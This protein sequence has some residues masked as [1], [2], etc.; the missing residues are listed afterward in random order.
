MKTENKDVINICNLVVV[1]LF[2]VQIFLFAPFEYFLSNRENIWFNFRDLIPFAMVGFISSSVLLSLVLFLIS[3]KSKKLF[4]V[5]IVGIFA[6]CLSLYIQGT[7]LITNMGALD[8]KEPDWSQYMGAKWISICVW[9]FIFGILYFAL[10]K[11]NYEKLARM[12]KIVSICLILVQVVTILTVGIA[13]NGFVSKQEMLACKNDQFSLSKGENFIILVLDS[14]DAR[15]FERIRNE[16]N[17]NEILRDFTYYNNTTPSFVLTDL[18][19]PQIITGENYAEGEIYEEY[20]NQAFDA[21]PLLNYLQDNDWNYGIYTST[22]LGSVGA[23]NNSINCRMGSFTV[24]S[25]RRLAKYMYKLLGMRYLP[26]P[27]QKYCW[28]YPDEMDNL[29]C[30]QNSK[31]ELYYEFNMPFYEEMNQIEAINDKN[32]F[33]FYHIDGTHIPYTM[34]RDV[35]STDTTFNTIDEEARG[36]MVIISKFLGLLKTKDLYDNATIILMADHGY[37]GFRQSPLFMIKEKNSTHEFMEYDVPVEYNEFQDICTLLLEHENVND[38]LKG[39]EKNLNNRE[40][41]FY[42]K[43]KSS[44]SSENKFTLI[45]YKTMGDSFDDSAVTEIKN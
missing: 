36:C 34:S 20:L 15:A 1:L 33:R 4:A 39:K 42:K 37:E 24:S 31:D 41:S 10:L 14:Y 45:R 18:S 2:G 28:F 40:F 25:H 38:Y 30:P 35:V 29:R 43:D 13:K 32:T 27:L 19:I 9:I 21:S 44:N 22:T 17:Y 7:Y 6:L 5:L 23:I 26:F 11:W 8:G 16:D 3:K 12:I